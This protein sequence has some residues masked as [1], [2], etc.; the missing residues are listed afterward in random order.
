[1]RRDRVPAGSV[2]GRPLLALGAE[3]GAF[4]DAGSP[5][6]QAPQIVQLGPA[7]RALPDNLYRI[8][9]RG[10]YGEG[11]LHTDIVGD[12]SD[13]EGASNAA[14][15]PADN[16]T[17]EPLDALSFTFPNPEVDLDGIPGEELLHLGVGGK[18]D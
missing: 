15:P 4:L 18:V 5:A 11:A 17:L 12:P 14:F 13:G 16:H 9:Q 8:Q 2:L 1:V 7:D 3:L 6:R 10:V